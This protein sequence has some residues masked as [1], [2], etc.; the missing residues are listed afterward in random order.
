[1]IDDTMVK[2]SSGHHSN[3]HKTGMHETRYKKLKDAKKSP[4]TP[5]EVS[6]LLYFSATTLGTNIV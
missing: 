4:L 6:T 5:E 2:Q 3:K 1:M